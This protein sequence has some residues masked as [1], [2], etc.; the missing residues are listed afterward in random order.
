MKKFNKYHFVVTGYNNIDLVSELLHLKAIEVKQTKF[1]NT[2]GVTYRTDPI[3]NPN[4][5]AIMGL[6]RYCQRKQYF[7][8]ITPPRD[9]IGSDSSDVRFSHALEEKENVP[10]EEP[11]RAFLK[12]PNKDTMLELG[13]R[14]R[15]YYY[16]PPGFEMDRPNTGISDIPYF[17]FNAL[18]SLK[19]FT[20][21]MLRKDGVI[22]NHQSV[23]IDRVRRF[24][25][26]K[27]Y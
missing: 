19:E 16:G 13:T 11:L 18:H 4:D 5:M 14:Y 21:I 24:W 25:T 3:K 26:S 8:D 2:F 22:D 23:S 10:F 12:N 15:A 6:I 9:Y 7:K 27:T 20:E 17:E 1:S